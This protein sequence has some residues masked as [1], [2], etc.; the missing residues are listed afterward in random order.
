MRAIF[1]I[2]LIC[3]I[4]ISTA[5]AGFVQ[6][7][8]GIEH[9]DTAVDM[10]YNGQYNPDNNI[11][12]SEHIRG[13]V[14]IIGYKN[15]IC[16]DG[17][18]YVPVLQ[19]DQVIVK[20]EVWDELLGFNDN[21]DWVRAPNEEVAPYPQTTI[22]GNV[23]HTMVNI[24]L[25]WHRSTQRSRTIC[26]LNGCK[27]YTWISKDYYDEYATFT[28][29]TTIPM[30]FEYNG[31][32]NASI[33]VVVY[34]NSI[35]PKTSIQILNLPDNTVSINYTYN[36]ESITHYNF[37]AIQEYTDKNCPFMNLT[38]V[39]IWID[40]DNLSQMNGFVIIPSMNFSSD[41]LSVVIS[42]PYK[43]YELTN[44]TVHE[45]KWHGIKDTFSSFFFLFITIC[46]IFIIG[47]YVQLRR[48]LYH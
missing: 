48:L 45:I 37:R 47:V 44:I 5:S 32:E 43:S 46:G 39:D 36:N 1:K 9:L 41:N 33:D 31:I 18:Y 29:T 4:F 28:D 35:S 17:E 12:A 7:L 6:D 27:T 11:Q 3:T 23:A 16:I 25:L 21:L 14:D 22:I 15:M 38:P 13:W 24:H 2:V 10:R 40:D 30:K 19:A 8:F 34:N 26:G 42:D 20:C